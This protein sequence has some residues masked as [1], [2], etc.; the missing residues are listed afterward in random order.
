MAITI[1]YLYPVTGTTPPTFL[2]SLNVTAVT[3][4]I[5]A[6]SAPDT[7]AVITH[8]FAL[9]AADISAG[10]PNVLVEPIDSLAASSDWWIQSLD[11][12][13]VGLA[14]LTSTAGQDTVPQIK[15]KVSRPS[16]LTR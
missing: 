9:P 7:A 8:N 14:R 11:P 16:T 15:V 10:W 12:N 5:F 2:Q 4:T 1:N 13:Y 3:A 6:T